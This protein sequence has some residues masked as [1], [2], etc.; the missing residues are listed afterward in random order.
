MES[1]S[2]LRTRAALA[3]AALLLGTATH[4]AT[5][6]TDAAFASALGETPAG[7][8]T[9]AQLKTQPQRP[10]AAT[11]DMV[12][13]APADAWKKILDKVK[14]DGVKRADEDF[15]TQSLSVFSGDRARG[16][17]VHRVTVFFSA[18]QNLKVVGVEFV[19]EQGTLLWTQDLMGTDHWDILADYSGKAG[20][21]I[22][23]QSTYEPG[24]SRIPGTPTV[25][26]LADPR[27]KASFDKMIAF[28]AS[29]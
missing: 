22:F 9:M 26:D 17:E 7:L 15:F 29:R 19:H 28:W 24:A 6:Q 11:Q 12:P 18:S 5:A 8:A 14:R 16:Y 4:S 3:A 23:E 20:H 13:T 2:G 1:P 10:A 25:V 27:V 21:A